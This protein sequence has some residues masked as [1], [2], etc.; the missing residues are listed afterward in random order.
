MRIQQLDRQDSQ[1]L[2]HRIFICLF[3]SGRIHSRAEDILCFWQHVS[4]PPRELFLPQ[5]SSWHRFARE[6]FLPFSVFIPAGKKKM[7]SSVRSLWE[8]WFWHRFWE[9]DPIWYSWH[10]WDVLLLAEAGPGHLFPGSE[11]PLQSPGSLTDS[12]TKENFVRNRNN[13]HI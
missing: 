3:P 8:C 9:L 6:K 1:Q 5:V 12:S 4:S 10:S 2:Q 11:I 13:T 7:H